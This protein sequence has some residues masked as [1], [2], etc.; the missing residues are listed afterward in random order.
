MLRLF[1]AVFFVC[2]VGCVAPSS[3]PEP[4]VLEA[5]EIAVEIAGDD[6]TLEGNFALPQRLEGEGVAGVVLVH[7]SGPQSRDVV[8]SGQLNMSFGDIEFAAFA[9]LS[10]ALSEAGVAVLRYDKRTC[11]SAGGYC[12]NDYPMP[13]PNVLVSHFVEDA[14]T[15]ADWLSSHEAVDSERVFVVG[16]S[17]GAAMMPA[18]LAGDSGLAGGVSLAGNYR[19]IDAILRYQLEFSEGLMLAAGYS[20]AAIDSQLESLTALVESVEALRAGNFAGSSIGGA[21]VAFWQDWLSLGDQRPALVAAEERPMFAINGD[22]DWNVPHD[23]ELLL[24]EEAGVETLLLSCVTHALN[25]VE[26]DEIGDRVEPELLDALSR[27]ILE[28]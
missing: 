20:Q 23:P 28:H 17:Q 3:Q 16:H 7:G 10:A 2:T 4:V 11:T 15:A 12:D 14:L 5:E 1:F 6:L 13:D 18:M 19:P 22:Y 24:W 21:S 8:S 9:G 27:W 26:A 25:C